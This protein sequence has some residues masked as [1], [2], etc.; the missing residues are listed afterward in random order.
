MLLGCTTHACTIF[1]HGRDEQ[2]GE[3]RSVKAVEN[4]LTLIRNVSST[5]DPDDDRVLGNPLLAPTLFMAARILCHRFV[6]QGGE[7]GN[8]NGTVRSQV[9]ILLD[10]LGRMEEGWPKL[11]GLMKTIICEDA[12]GDC[13]A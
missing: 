12:K 13:K 10:A 6:S 5:L 1:L 8:G 11:A 9:E 3:Q 2:D 7:T 4:I